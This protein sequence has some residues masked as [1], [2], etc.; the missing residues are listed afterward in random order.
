MNANDILSRVAAVTFYTVRMWNTKPP[1]KYGPVTI[2]KDIYRYASKPQQELLR[3]RS[4]YWTNFARQCR[5]NN[6]KE[7]PTI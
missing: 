4:R 1:S 5:V 6:Q 7:F 2:F 3:N